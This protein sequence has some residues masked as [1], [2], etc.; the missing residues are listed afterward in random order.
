MLSYKNH[1]LD[2]FLVDVVRLSSPQLHPNDLIR[3][4]KIENFELQ[5]FQERNSNAEKDFAAKLNDAI[6]V[7]KKARHIAKQFRDYAD[8][9]EAKVQA[10]EVSI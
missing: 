9:F 10:Q 4:G 3:S 5:A 7:Q 6:R 8:F 1:A 2:E